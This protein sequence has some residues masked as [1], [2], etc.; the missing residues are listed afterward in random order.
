M[1]AAYNFIEQ[2]SL[3]LFPSFSNS[4]ERKPDPEDEVICMH[5]VYSRQSKHY[6]AILVHCRQ[7]VSRSASFVIGY[8]MKKQEMTS[9]EALAHVRMFRPIVSPNA[10]F[11]AQL[12][13]YDEILSLERAKM[14][15][16]SGGMAPAL[17][18]VE[19]VGA[20]GPVGPIGP[21]GPSLPTTSSA[22]LRIGPAM[23]PRKGGTTER[24]DEEKE[25][26]GPQL[27]SRP[28]DRPPPSSEEQIGP[29]LPPGFGSAT[30]RSAP[31]IGPSLPPHL[32]RHA[33]LEIGPAARSESGGPSE[34][35]ARTRTAGVS[36]GE[37]AP[38]QPAQ[39]D[40]TSQKLSKEEVLLSE[41]N[42]AMI[43][44][45]I[46]KHLLKRTYETQAS[47]ASAAGLTLPSDD[48]RSS[49]KKLRVEP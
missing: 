22:G 19:A 27:P 25:A 4:G 47:D 49:E 23:P 13:R 5:A 29:A 46:P 34:E 40:R 17:P 28:R 12:K 38:S 6:G 18:A 10:A 15:E 37:T 24:A 21:I 1:E 31:S 32:Q 30:S 48:N 39:D 14:I 8:L 16:R 26:I 3:F 44:P 41:T 20:I 7:G 11:M 42:E 36:R 35:Q 33:E 2:V 9:A 43:G 45:A